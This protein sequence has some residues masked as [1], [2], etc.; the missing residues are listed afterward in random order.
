MKK[1]TTQSSRLIVLGL[2]LLFH[3]GIFLSISNPTLAAADQE[4]E[5]NKWY[6]HR[7]HLILSPYSC[8]AGVAG[9]YA[10]PD[11]HVNSWLMSQAYIPVEQGW[12][13]P[14][15]TFWTKHYTRR[16]INFC[17]VE[18]QKEGSVQWERIKVIGGSRDW[19]KMSLDLS[20]YRG[21][22]I[23]VKF[24]CEPNRGTE[25]GRFLNLFNKQILYLQEVKIISDAAT[26]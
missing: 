10:N 23:R 1:I 19:Y 11:Y 4:V 2:F 12:K 26:E 7:F 24:Y 25:E 16:Q 18:V 9:C 21:E 13:Q 3:I 14:A 22:R 15:L 6:F 17:Y 8:H 5:I 20:P